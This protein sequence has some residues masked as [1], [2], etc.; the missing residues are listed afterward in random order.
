MAFSLPEQFPAPKYNWLHQRV[1]GQP[2]GTG[3]FEAYGPWLRVKTIAYDLGMWTETAGYKVNIWIQTVW[4][5]QEVKSKVASGSRAWFDELHLIKAIRNWK[6]ALSIDLE[7]IKN[8]GAHGERHMLI[9]A[10]PFLISDK[11]NRI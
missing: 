10:W 5:V 3:S 2:Q 1:K 9:S 7:V 8:T 4:Q 11:R 6:L